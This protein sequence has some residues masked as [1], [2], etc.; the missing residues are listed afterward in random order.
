VLR[1]EAVGA[2][3]S[4]EAAPLQQCSAQLLKPNFETYGR[5]KVFILAASGNLGWF[6]STARDR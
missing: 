1:E 5:T 6:S 4:P 3:A 2:V